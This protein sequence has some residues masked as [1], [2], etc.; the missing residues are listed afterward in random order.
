[1]EDINNGNFF[2]IS[3]LHIKQIVAYK[4]S[5]QNISIPIYKWNLKTSFETRKK[6]F[7]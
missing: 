6:I 2:I 4:L 5:I 7:I 3:I 1:M